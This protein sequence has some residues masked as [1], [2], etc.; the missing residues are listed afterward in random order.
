MHFEKWLKNELRI[1][2]NHIW[3][4]NT[5]YFLVRKKIAN[6]SCMELKIHNPNGGNIVYDKP[7]PIFYF[8]S[9]KYQKL[10]SEKNFK[11]CQNLFLWKNAVT[12][13][14][15]K[16][17]ITFIPLIVI[18]WIKACYV[19]MNLCNQIQKK[20][21]FFCKEKQFFLDCPRCTC[22]HWKQ[23]KPY[24]FYTT[25]WNYTK[26]SLTWKVWQLETL[27]NLTRNLWEVQGLYDLPKNT[28]KT[29][30]GLLR[31]LGVNPYR[32]KEY[33]LPKSLPN[34]RF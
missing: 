24:N 11:D 20:I 31:T 5:S 33:L 34:Y 29:Q 21:R 6:H 10:N 23:K 4:K 25:Y 15:T 18:W 17:F 32:P 26:Q 16:I 2:K 9:L 28:Q 13:C 14:K 22:W 1:L 30:S 27:V 8:I 7:H 12:T 3:T 19:H